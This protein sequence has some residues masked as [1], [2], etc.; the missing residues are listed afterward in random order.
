MRHS[1]RIRARVVLAAFLALALF[2]WTDVL[3]WQRL[4]EGQPFIAHF[5][6]G[7][8]HD[9]MR[10]ALDAIA[11]SGALLLWGHWAEMVFYPLT[12]Y[13]FY[14]NGFVDLLYYW[15]DGRA[16][17]QDL[18]WLN[19][20]WHPYILLWPR[21]AASLVA[22]VALWAVA[23]AGLWIVVSRQLA[24]VSRQESVGSSQ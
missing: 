13:L 11:L 7:R 18:F 1:L 20:K 23:W 19:D 16:I 10:V 6:D 4:I 22:N 12:V 14:R 5:M 9:G 3:V 21:T 8:F 17:P 2:A 15:L 24:V